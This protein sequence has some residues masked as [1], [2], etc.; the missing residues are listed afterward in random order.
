MTSGAGQT[1][2]IS[3]CLSAKF[4]RV[5]DAWNAAQPDPPPSRSEAIRF[6]LYVRLIAPGLL[7]I[8]ANEKLK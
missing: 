6:A 3:L 2:I 1:P 5:I 4:L 8:E 7:S